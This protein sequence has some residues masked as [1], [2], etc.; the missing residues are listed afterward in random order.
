MSSAPQWK[1][2]TK[3]QCEQYVQFATRRNPVVKF[4]LEKLKLAGCEV[5]GNFIH[6][7]ECSMDAGGG[8]RAPD[9]VVMCYNHVASQEEVNLVLAHELIHAY[10][11]CRGKDIDWTNCEHHACSEVRAANLSG[12][13]HWWQ[14]FRRGNMTLAAQH[15][16]CARRRAELSVAMNPYCKGLKGKA[17]VDRV[18]KPCFEDT[19][20]FDAIP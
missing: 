17:A 12:D 13:C 9:G 8:F 1:G 14:E 5:K 10:D 7:E 11:H 16:S 2:S 15:Q 19:A 6:L 20:P 18:F 4:M 3:E